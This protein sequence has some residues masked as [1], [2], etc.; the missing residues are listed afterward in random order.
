MTVDNN[1][2]PLRVA[3]SLGCAD[4]I[5][6][7]RTTTAAEAEIQIKPLTASKKRGQ[8]GCAATIVLPESQNAFDYAAKITRKH[9]VIMTVSVVTL[10]ILL[11]M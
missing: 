8:P 6:D 10:A 5:L 3:K 4:L 11:L 2:E 9:G 1:D 7:A